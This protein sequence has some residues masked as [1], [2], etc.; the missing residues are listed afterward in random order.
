MKNFKI[1]IQL[2]SIREEMEADMDAALGAVK[3]MGYDY[4]EFA[5]YFGKTAEE[6]RA[7]LD[8][9]GLT[10]ISAHQGPEVFWY[11]DEEKEIDF[12]KTLGVKYCAIPWY[13]V[14]EYVERWNET[15]ERFTKLGEKLKENGI[16]LLYHNHD[17][18]LGKIG[19]EAILDKLY[20]SVPA[21]VL[22][23]EF[24]TCWLHYAGKDPAEYLSG[25][26]DR[27]IDVV[28]LK[29]FTCKKLGGGPVYDLIGVN[30]DEARKKEKAENGFKFMSLGYGM[31][32]F[33]AIIEACERIGAEYLI[34]EQ[35][36]WYDGETAL[37]CAAKSRAYLKEAFGL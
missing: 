17:F 11:G 36:K 35:D 21:D 31:Q 8:K 34:V 19:G 29:D 22:Q 25:Y 7:L 1:G 24:D 14:D 20:A 15:V 9:H 37:E 16:Q 4:V 27:R 10:A 13:S 32:D 18:E 26:A 30:D 23:P 5:G 33:G 6:V 28:H 12:L 3:A 2:Y